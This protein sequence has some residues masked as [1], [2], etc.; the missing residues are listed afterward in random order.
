MAAVCGVPSSQ[1]ASSTASAA[2]MAT[3]VSASRWRT[4]WN[5]A[6]GWPNW[7][8]SRRAGAPARASRLDAPTSSWPSASWPRATAAPPVDGSDL[9]ERR[10]RRPTTSTRPSDGSM[11]SIGRARND[12]VSTSKATSDSPA[13]DDDAPP[14]R[15]AGARSRRRRCR[16]RSCPARRHSPIGGSS[17]GGASTP[18]ASASTRSSADDVAFAAPWCANSTDTAARASSASASR[19][20]RSSSAASSAAPVWLARGVL[21]AALE[22]REVLARRSPVVPEVEQAPGDDVALDLGAA[23][24]DGCGARVEELARATAR[25]GRRRPS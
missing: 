20:P 3:S 4:A 14:C 11:P 16:R 19:Q 10:R 9:A 15:A 12:E 7:T 25:S 8:R 18:S 23:A 5:L 21:E 22:Q 1:A 13:R 6:M 2:S 24:V 17:T